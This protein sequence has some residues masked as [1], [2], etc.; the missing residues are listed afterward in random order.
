MLVVKIPLLAR[1]QIHLSRSRALQTEQCCLELAVSGL[2]PRP[3]TAEGGTPSPDASLRGVKQ[4]ISDSNAVPTVSNSGS[5]SVSRRMQFGQK[6]AY[7]INVGGIPS[8]LATGS[9]AV[10]TRICVWR[11]AGK[12][13]DA[14]SFA[15]SERIVSVFLLK[16]SYLRVYPLNT[17]ISHCFVLTV[18]CFLWGDPT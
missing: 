1:V 4:Y 13:M 18:P 17:T 12:W 3:P 7:E 10:K 5:A 15:S 14:L 2:L 16:W 11:N 8:A 9:T 6:C